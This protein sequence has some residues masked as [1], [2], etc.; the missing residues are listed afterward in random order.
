MRN[1]AAQLSIILV[2]KMPPC[3]VIGELERGPY[4]PAEWWVLP[5]SVE[6]EYAINSIVSIL[7]GT[8]TELERCAKVEVWA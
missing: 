3:H 7:T 5:P 8:R 2:F 1:K 6:E 4:E